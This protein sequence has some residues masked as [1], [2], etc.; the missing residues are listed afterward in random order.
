MSIATTTYME[1]PPGVFLLNLSIDKHCLHI[2]KNILINKLHHTQSQYDEC[3]FYHK[4]SI[5]SVY[6]NNGILI[7][8][9]RDNI[10]SQISEFKAIFDI[11]VQ[12]NL[13]DYLRIRIERNSDNCIHMMQPHLIASILVDLQLA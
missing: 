2:I 3:V 11:E 1:L 9:S 8:P 4:S 12:G 10:K 6:T 13:N 5:L 7:D